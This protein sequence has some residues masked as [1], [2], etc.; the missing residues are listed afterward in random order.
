MPKLR[1]PQQLNQLF[2]Q[3]KQK[4]IKNNNNQPK[5]DIKQE[6]ADKRDNIIKWHQQWL[7]SIKHTEP[8]QY[9]HISIY[10]SSLIVRESKESELF[11]TRQELQQWENEN[12]KCIDWNKWDELVNKFK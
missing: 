6:K 8:E 11:H 1:T 12:C 3:Y 7:E 5:E 2:Q 10:H 4:R 9:N